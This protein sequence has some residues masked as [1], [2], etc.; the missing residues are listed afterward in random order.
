MTL[1][2]EGFENLQ[3]LKIALIDGKLRQRGTGEPV[4][5]ARELVCV[6]AYQAL[7]GSPGLAWIKYP[8]LPTLPHQAEPHDARVPG[9]RHKPRLPRRSR[10]F[11]KFHVSVSD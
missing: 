8:P 9:N 4:L 5:I 6:A 1:L 2:A 11:L 7:P 10:N 3:R